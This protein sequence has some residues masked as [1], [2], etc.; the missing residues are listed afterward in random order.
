[1]IDMDYGIIGTFLFTF[2]LGLFIGVIWNF[3][4]M[5]RLFSKTEKG[6]EAWQD[7]IERRKESKK[8]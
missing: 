3:Y 8:D 4:T 2:S 5:K 1:M 7:V 6:T